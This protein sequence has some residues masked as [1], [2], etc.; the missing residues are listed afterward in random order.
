MSRFIQATP[1]PLPQTKASGQIALLYAG[2]IVVMLVAQLFTFDEFIELIVSY[3]LPVGEGLAYSLAAIIIVIEFFIL[4]FL[5]RMK[6]SVGFRYLSALCGMLVALVWIGIS[7]WVV[8]T[9][10]A[11]ETIGFIGTVV[12]LT[13]GLWALFF[14]ISLGFLAA[15]TTWG[16]WPRYVSKK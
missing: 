14:S 16:L 2:L 15:W 3:N 8:F 7:A 9:N 6:V 11:V 12:P 13:P 10:Q 4:S 5:L 1:A